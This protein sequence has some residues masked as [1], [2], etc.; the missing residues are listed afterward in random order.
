MKSIDKPYKSLLILVLTFISF[1]CTKQAATK[2]ILVRAQSIVEQQPD[3]ALR[4]LQSVLFPENFDKSR[5]NKYYL[6]LLQAKDK[7]YKDITSDTV[8]FTVK[9][10]Y[11]QVKDY[12][13]AAMAAYYCGRLWH[14]RNNMSEAVKAYT[15][16]E[17]L[18]DKTDNDNLKGLI[19]S[20]LGI[21][22]MEHSS[23]ETA[24]ELLKNAVVW[25]DKAKNY[26]NEISSL[27]TIGDCL[28]LSKQTDSAFYYYNQSLKLA[29]LHNM[30]K[31]QSEVINNKAVIY[32]EQGNYDQAKKLFHEALALTNDSLE[33]AR[34]LLNIAQVYELENKMDS[35]NS[36]LKMALAFHISNP[37]LMRSSYKL[38]SEIEEKGNRYQDALNDYKEY[39]KYTEK[40][41]DNAK[42]N[43]L[44]EVQ[45]KYDF[46]KLKNAKNQLIIRQ[47]GALNILYLVLLISGIIIFLYYRSIFRNKRLLLEFE[48]KVESLQRIAEN[49]SKEKQSFRNIVIQHFEIMKKTTLIESEISDDERKSGQKLLKKFNKIVYGQD[50]L[51]WGKMYFIMNSLYNGLYDEIKKKYTQW[52]EMDF[53]IF[54]MSNEN[55]FTDKEISIILNNTIPMIRKIRSKIRK[56]MGI[57][58]YSH[59]FI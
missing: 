40:V 12:P 52:D 10:Y 1:S 6:L 26:R 14:E 2:D 49:Y 27:K 50:T 28:G 20:N 51:D 41:W 21:L 37:W 31:Q 43:E 53:R 9:D 7:D 44:Q 24:I 36:Y 17:T 23:Y 29:V 4:M 15:E 55:Q 42:N 8:I 32:Q 39:Y 58:K 54:C 45:A 11:L 18:A 38:S 19:Q 16:A 34:T 22:H 13:N 33:Q 47:K 35:V 30:S 57:P 46:E 3:S 25:Y 59:N 48:Q 56:D 5:F